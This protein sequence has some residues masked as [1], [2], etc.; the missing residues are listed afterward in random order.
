MRIGVVEPV[1]CEVEGEGHVVGVARVVV[2]VFEAAVVAVGVSFRQRLA[3]GVVDR[4]GDLV[5]VLIDSEEGR[6]ENTCAVEDFAYPDGYVALQVFA[7][8]A[9]LC[10]GRVVKLRAYTPSACVIDVSCGI[11]PILGHE[12]IT[13]GNREIVN[14]VVPCDG[15]LVVLYR[16]A[17][18]GLPYS[19]PRRSSVLEEAEII[20]SVASV[21]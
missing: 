15:F 12:Y 1:L 19:L 9:A 17:D 5:S 11:T 13:V 8:L 3:P 7:R 4:V 21:L 18:L 2:E 16:R 6:A 14:N 10:S 20:R